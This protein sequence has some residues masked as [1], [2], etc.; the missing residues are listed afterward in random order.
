MAN[1]TLDKG[2]L[3][4]ATVAVQFW[5]DGAAGRVVKLTAG[6]DWTAEVEAIPAPTVE[7]R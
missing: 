2:P 1:I 5:E 7:A 3:V 4:A 6:V